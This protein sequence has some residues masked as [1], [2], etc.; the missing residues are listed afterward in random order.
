MNTVN[1]FHISRT[2][3]DVE[4]KVLSGIASI[5]DHGDDSFVAVE[6]WKGGDV[7]FT[8]FLDFKV[9]KLVS[10][11]QFH[12]VLA[13]FQ[14]VTEDILM[15]REKGEEFQAIFGNKD[16]SKLLNSFLRRNLTVDLVLDK[17]SEQ[18]PS[19][20]TDIDKEILGTA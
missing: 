9:R 7:L 18:G 8:F 14:N 4:K 17:I 20:I 19:S 15:S 13:E 5:L 1:F 10:L 3:E 16:Y 6:S 11:F 12:S 2:S